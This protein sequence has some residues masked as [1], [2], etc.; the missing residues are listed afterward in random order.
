[1]L[2]PNQ[3]RF[4]YG[5]NLQPPPGFDLDAAI[6]TSY[7]LDLNALLAIPI[8]LCFRD[9]L[10]GDL[11]GEKIALFEALEQLKGKL[12]AKMELKLEL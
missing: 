10:E 4:D 3:C 1:M 2:T 7:S 11:K 9:T 5:K 12:K 8:A 6:A